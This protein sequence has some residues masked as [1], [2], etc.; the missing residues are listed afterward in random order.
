VPDGRCGPESRE[1][2]LV[3]A[4]SPVASNGQLVVVERDAA[5]ARTLS[6]YVESTQLRG[7]IQSAALVERGTGRL[8][9]TLPVTIGPDSIALHDSAIPYTGTLAFDRFFDLA[10]SEQIVMALDTS[11]TAAPRVELVLQLYEYK[12]WSQPYCS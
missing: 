2:I 9:M 5:P 8:V 3:T 7:H 11:R 10:R 6:W 4:P 12:P 1:L